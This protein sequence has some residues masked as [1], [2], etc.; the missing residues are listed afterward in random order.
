MTVEQDKAGRDFS[1]LGQLAQMVLVAAREHAVRYGFQTDMTII[2]GYGLWR[3]LLIEAR[4]ILPLTL[5]E[6]PDDDLVLNVHGGRSARVV[7]TR[8]SRNFGDRS[9]QLTYTSTFNGSIE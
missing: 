4:K 8:A 9:W 1:P 7:P 2:V 3:D 6:Y 5:A